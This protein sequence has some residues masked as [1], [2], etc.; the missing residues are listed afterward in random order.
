MIVDLPEEYWAANEFIDVIHEED[1]LCWLW[2]YPQIFIWPYRV[3]WLYTPVT[4]N[5]KWPGDLWGID[6]IGNL[7]IIEA[8]QCKRK[9]DGYIDFVKYHRS[10]REEFT[11]CHWQSKW[12]K[13]FL[14]EVQFPNGWMERSLG[15]TDGIIPRSNKRSHIRRWTSISQIID[16][17]IRNGQYERNIRQYLQIRHQLNNPPPYYVGLMIETD[18]KYPI[19]TEA[20]L[21]SARN[22]KEITSEDH[23][24]AI[25]LRCKKLSD[26]KGLIEIRVI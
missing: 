10:Y 24:I 22:L 14:S 11:S 2:A 18:S 6:S 20:A 15:K 13:H 16:D 23:V 21:S 8:K 26:K 5:A 12:K 19:L 25:A 17:Y 1:A 9:D 4:G 3:E 7:I